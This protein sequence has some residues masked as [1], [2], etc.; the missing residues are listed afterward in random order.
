MNDGAEGFHGWVEAE[1]LRVCEHARGNQPARLD[2]VTGKRSRP[3][4]WWKLTLDRPGPVGRTQASGP[5]TDLRP[6]AS[7]PRGPLPIRREVA[8]PCGRYRT[9]PPQ[10]PC[11]GRPHLQT[12]D[13]RAEPILCVRRRGGAEPAIR[14]SLGV[15]RRPPSRLA[16]VEADGERATRNDRQSPGHQS[17][18]RVVSPPVPREGRAGPASRRW[19]SCRE[20]PALTRV[21]IL[22]QSL[23]DWLGVRGP[24]LAHE[25]A[26]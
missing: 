3:A 26:R 1:G 19:V 20:R 2:G 6:S 17:P 13:Q 18:A 7:P 15:P 14:A 9:V 23:A 21:S 16:H 5:S 24:A 25:A 11:R 4:V 10:R 8:L 22:I 12:G